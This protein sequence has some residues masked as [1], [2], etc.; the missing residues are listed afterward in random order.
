MKY[1]YAGFLV[2]LLLVTTGQRISAA[3]LTERQFPMY[4]AATGQK[5][6]WEA[7]MQ[8]VEQS[9]VIILGERHNDAWGHRFQ[10][11]VVRE[12]TRLWPGSAVSLEMLER[13][14]QPLLNAYLQGRLSYD[15]FLKAAGVANWAGEGT[16]LVWYQ[17]V[18]N[19]ARSAFSPVVAANA[20]RSYVRQARLEG[21]S[22]LAS[23]PVSQKKLFEI[24]PP[25]PEEHYLARFA[26]L[27]SAHSPGGSP[28]DENLLAFFRS[29]QVWDATM[30][31]SVVCQA[32][33]SPKVFHLV[34]QFHSDFDGGLVVRIRNLNPHLRI[35]NISMQ[36]DHPSPTFR[37]EDRGRADIVVYTHPSLLRPGGLPV[38]P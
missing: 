9:D 5:I 27:M 21:F 23:L 24:P 14:H 15:N 17:P 37:E 32:R 4:Q 33:R 2:S 31:S 18:L 22:S 29:Q 6:D 12:G 25:V 36:S 13:H 16:W 1:L 8:Q 34:G 19:A 38:S 35:L 7:L 30:A 26:G 3:V 11:E 10:R 20:P 28:P